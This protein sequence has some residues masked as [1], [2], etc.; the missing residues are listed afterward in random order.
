[1]WLF[2]VI[3]II[4]II[5]IITIL[6]LFIRNNVFENLTGTQLFTKITAFYRKKF[7]TLPETA[8]HYSL[9]W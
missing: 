4:I 8:H 7:I 6:L 3:I 2:P 1:M 9:R 5:I